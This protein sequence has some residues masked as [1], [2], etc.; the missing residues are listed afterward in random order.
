L[1][2]Q[3]RAAWSNV[4]LQIDDS[5]LEASAVNDLFGAGGREFLQDHNHVPLVA[6]II[7][8]AMYRDQH[9]RYYA[10]ADPSEYEAPSDYAEE[11]IEDPVLHTTDQFFFATSPAAVRDS[12][13]ADTAVPPESLTW[14]AVDEVLLLTRIGT[15]QTLAVTVIERLKPTPDNPRV[16]SG[17]I[18]LDAQLPTAFFGAKHTALAVFNSMC[19]SIA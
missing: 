11:V 13:S 14:P 1:P 10:C 5:M 7:A 19:A 2:S 4:Q 12:R 3:L 16:A 9:G 18:R 15:N 17:L 8:S 6:H